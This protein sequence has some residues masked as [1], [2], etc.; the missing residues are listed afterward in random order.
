MQ[1]LVIVLISIRITIPILIPIPIPITSTI[2]NYTTCLVD[3]G[4]A[5]KRAGVFNVVGALAEAQPRLRDLQRI[6]GDGCNPLC[7]GAQRKRL[8]CTTRTV[9]VLAFVPVH[10]FLFPALACKASPKKLLL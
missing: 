2:T 4:E 5:V 6:R 7:K 1:L 10:V 9:S 8:R 3:P